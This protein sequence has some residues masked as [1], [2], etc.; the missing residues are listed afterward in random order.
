MVRPPLLS[1]LTWQRYYLFPVV[2]GSLL[3]SLA[4]GWCLAAALRRLRPV[5]GGA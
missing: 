2:L 4:V 3:A 5:A 1:P